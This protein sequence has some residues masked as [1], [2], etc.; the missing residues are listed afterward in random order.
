MLSKEKR[1]NLNLSFRWTASGEKISLPFVKIFY[2]TGHNSNP[3]IGVSLSKTNFKTAIERNR[4]KR[5]LSEAFNELYPKIEPH[6]NI[7]AIP[8]TQVLKLSSKEILKVLKDNFNR[9]S[10]LR[11]Y[12]ERPF[13]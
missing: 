7:V 10:L 4:A 5:L 11:M 13:K 6:L 2:R 3:L 12:N 9:K 8:Y 1:L